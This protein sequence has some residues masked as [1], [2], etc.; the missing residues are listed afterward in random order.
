MFP[1]FCGPM[2]VTGWLLMLLFWAGLIALVVW[3]IA[4]LFPDRHEP[5]EPLVSPQ[6]RRG[7]EETPSP[8]VD[9]GR[10]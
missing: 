10:R 2:G 1:T 7:E 6:R 3:G 8:L 4:R 9:S 5:T